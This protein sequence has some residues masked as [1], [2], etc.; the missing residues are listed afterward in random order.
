[1]KIKFLLLFAL[2]STLAMASFTN[3]D[4]DRDS[5]T[6]GI[7]II[8]CKALEALWDS[9][10]GPN[11][12]NNRGWDTNISLA[13]SDD[14]WYG[15]Q[16]RSGHVTGIAMGDPDEFSSPTNI[17]Y[18]RYSDGPGTQMSGEPLE[19]KDLLNGKSISDY[20]NN[21]VGTI[22][23]EITNLSELLYMSFF[24]NHLSGT[25]PPLGKL[26]N[27]REIDLAH[28]QLTGSIPADLNETNL[29]YLYLNH[30]Q[31]TGTIP[32]EL[33]GTN[34]NGGFVTEFFVNNNN[35]TGTIPNTIY[36]FHIDLSHNQLTGPLPKDLSNF[37]DNRT[38]F[39]LSHNKFT[40]TIPSEY[41][42]NNVLEYLVLSDNQLTGEI[43]SSLSDIYTLVYFD[44]SNN[45]L[46]GTIPTKIFDNGLNAYF[47]VAHN[48][49]TGAIPAGIK[50]ITDY[51]NYSFNFSD[52]N[53]SG[54]IPKF[55][56][57]FSVMKG[58]APNHGL[59]A[60]DNR[61][62]FSDIE[63]NYLDTISLTN[64]SGGGVNGIDKN[65]GY[66]IST[67]Y[68]VDSNRTLASYD[69]KTGAIVGNN[70][71]GNADDANVIL[72]ANSPFTHVALLY[73]DVANDS[74]NS[75]NTD[76]TLAKKEIK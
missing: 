70:P 27:L 32:P 74:N 71:A 8:E 65:N 64:D 33:F 55:N 30:N 41:G 22:P 1:M 29:Q 26:P 40:G 68:I 60:F 15:I 24:A 16:V 4:C 36:A 51:E 31:L 73:K 56:K 48:Q 5:G 7:P 43:P 35:L 21:L 69:P 18:G 25:I 2:S 20:G 50:N 38:Y 9:T 75:D 63:P 19:T 39:N 17:E 23:E 54:L 37:L 67:Q 14:K 10:D 12:K 62:T 52:N 57:D 47:N 6:L 61:F 44:A 53:L 59:D 13:D 66:D 28:N 72:T 46:T 42:T 3:I 11:W 45:K 49:L 58:F 34:K 76:N